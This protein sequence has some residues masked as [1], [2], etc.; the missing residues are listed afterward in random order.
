MCFKICEFDCQV[1]AGKV[2]VV[3]DPPQQASAETQQG[4]YV[5]HVEWTKMNLLHKYDVFIVNFDCP[6]LQGDGIVQEGDILIPV[7][8]CFKKITSLMLH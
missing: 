5:T 1:S 2:V 8:F 7:R 4:K 3:L 6:E